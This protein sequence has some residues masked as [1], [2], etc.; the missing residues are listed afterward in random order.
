MSYSWVTIIYQQVI[1][2]IIELC[3]NVQI[4][5]PNIVGPATNH[6]C[7][8]GLGGIQNTMIPHGLLIS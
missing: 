5:D 2:V 3:G 4:N 7:K 8:G 6:F 1:N